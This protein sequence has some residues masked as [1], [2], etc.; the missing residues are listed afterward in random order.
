MKTNKILAA[1]WVLIAVILLYVMV[2]KIKNSNTGLMR[3]GEITRGELI[4]GK[5]KLRDSYSYPVASI[6]DVSVNVSSMTVRFE[7]ISGDNVIVEI[8]SNQEENVSVYE[9]D[10]VLNVLVPKNKNVVSINAGERSVVIKVPY[11]CEL[12][13]VSV[14]GSS[15]SIWM[16]GIKAAKFYVDVKS[17]SIHMDNVVGTESITAVSMSGSVK[18]SDVVTSR[19]DL[20]SSSGSV[21]YEG[22]CDSFILKSRS[23]SVKAELTKPFSGDSEISSSSGSIWLSVPSDSS[24]NVTYKVSSGSYHNRITGCDGKKGSETVGNGGPLLNVSASSGSIH[25]D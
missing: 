8:Y 14:D 1:I 20:S 22:E 25:I 17:S 10:S 15:G 9:A 7:R 5:A 23:G 13:T 24:F 3:L 2:I 19:L 18:M 16:D 4:F 12:N 11:T 21:K 6:N